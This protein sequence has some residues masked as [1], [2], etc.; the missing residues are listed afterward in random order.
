MITRL[1][2]GAG[3]PSFVFDLTDYGNGDRS[4]SL[5]PAGFT[6]HDAHIKP[7]CGAPQSPIDPCYPPNLLFRAGDQCYQRPSGHTGNS[8]EVTEGP[9]HGFPADCF[10]SCSTIEMDVLDHAIGF[11]YRQITTA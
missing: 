4:G 2:S 5:R 8:R 11:Q 9:H 1:T 7:I 3:D 10:R 6:S